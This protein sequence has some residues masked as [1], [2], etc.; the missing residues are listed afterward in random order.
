M[1]EIVINE[2]SKKGGN[3]QQQKNRMHGNN[4]I[5]IVKIYIACGL[6]AVDRFSFLTFHPWNPRTPFSHFY[7]CGGSKTFSFCTNV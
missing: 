6:F 3:Y 7:V 2:T 1:K 5:I 4:I